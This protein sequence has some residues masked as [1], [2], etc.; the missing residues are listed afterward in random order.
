MAQVGVRSVRDEAVCGKDGNF[1]GEEV[2]ERVVGPEAEE[3]PGEEEPEP[4]EEAWRVV[5][6]RGERGGRGGAE[7]GDEWGG[8]G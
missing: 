2:T 4:E 3:A 7:V 8:G 1:E 5:R 6:E